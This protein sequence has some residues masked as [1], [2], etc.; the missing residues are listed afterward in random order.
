MLVLSRRPNE[1]IMIGDSIRIT[2][3]SVRGNQVRIGI[4]APPDVTVLREELVVAREMLE[5][6]P[7]EAR[8]GHQAVLA[9]H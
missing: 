7:T 8:S 1:R 5:A 9:G 3:T 2:V 6:G 4:E